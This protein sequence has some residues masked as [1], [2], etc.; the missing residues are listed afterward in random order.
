MLRLV[1]KLLV[2]LIFFSS[3]KTALGARFVVEGP[4][5]AIEREALFELLLS[6]EPEKDNINALEG[7]LSFPANVTPVVVRDGGSAV[8][9]WI[10]RPRVTEKGEIEF[11][12][13]IPGGY[14]GGRGKVFS[15]IFKA[16]SAG[17]GEI[18]LKN[19]S[20]LRS[21]GRGSEVRS[22][23]NVY[24]Y[25]IESR[26]A[27]NPEALLSAMVDLTPPEGFTPIVGSDPAIFEGRYFVAFEAKDKGLGLAG[28]EILESR[29]KVRDFVS[30]HWEKVQSP[31]PLKDQ[32]LR[33]HIYVKAID[34]SGN[35]KLTVVSPLRRP[36]SPVGVI[37]WCII[38]VIIL[39]TL[40][41]RRRV[42]FR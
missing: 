21:D 39:G 40:I 35:E 28:Y 32:E 42:H 24:S 30:A 33:S 19:F 3:A 15:V 12:G 2:L 22:R 5:P 8:S 6:L 11:A 16:G 37:L 27:V 13:I 34:L 18:K 31:Y 26:L 4:P 41:R 36:L 9:F 20:T 14:T 25:V 29:K 38:F 10:I 7:T 1:T 23:A 17:N